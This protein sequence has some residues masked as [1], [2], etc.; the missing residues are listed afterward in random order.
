MQPVSKYVTYHHGGKRLIYE[1]YYGKLLKIAFR[2]VST[3]EQAQEVTH[4]GFVEIFQQLIRPA[5]DQSKRHD[6]DFPEW[7]T[8]IFIISIV[9]QMMSKPILQVPA[10]IPEHLWSNTDQTPTQEDIISIGLIKILKG[11][12]ARCRIIFNLYVI[13]GFSHDEIAGLLGITVKHSEFV[14]TKARRYCD[15]AVNLLLQSLSSRY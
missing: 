3:Y 10:P 5:T 13:D 15:K 8:R 6:I 14:L 11:L 7:V 4:N 9:E 12:A 1:E 2:Y